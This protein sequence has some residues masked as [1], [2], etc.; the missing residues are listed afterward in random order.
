MVVAAP[1]VSMAIPSVA[2]A[3]LAVLGAGLTR[4][5]EGLGKPMIVGLAFVTVFDVLQELI[6]MQSGAAIDLL[7]Q[8][9]YTCAGLTPQGALTIFVVASGGAFMWTRLLSAPARTLHAAFALPK[10]PH[11]GDKG[12]PPHPTA[13]RF[14]A[15]GSK[16]WRRRAP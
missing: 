2:G 13:R 4:A 1:L 5:P 12:R 3:L 9:I 10:A 8:S 15:A 7:R 6:Q 16:C 14:P 11:Q